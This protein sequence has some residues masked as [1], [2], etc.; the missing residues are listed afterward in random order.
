MMNIENLSKDE[1]LGLEVA[2]GQPIIYEY[3]TK[4]FNKLT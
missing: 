1:V 2:T 4:Q 3:S